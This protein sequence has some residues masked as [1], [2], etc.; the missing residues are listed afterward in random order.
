MAVDDNAVLLADPEVGDSLPAVATGPIS[1]HM[2]ATYA[3]GSADLNPIHTDL[4]FARDKAG[5]PD[6][7]VHGM[8]V[9]GYLARVATDVVRPEA[10]RRLTT[11]FRAMT[12]V[13]DDLRC[14]G[15]VK[16]VAPEG[17]GRLVTVELAATRGDGTVVATGEV[18]LFLP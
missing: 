18:D 2:I 8:L 4:D 9:M 17:P 3:A 7:I 16:A 13:H 15:R 11:Q 14:S 12:N 5:L 6:V 1:R 10:I